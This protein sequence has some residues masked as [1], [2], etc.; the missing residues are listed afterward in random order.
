MLPI[1]YTLLEQQGNITT[2]AP[3][4]SVLTKSAVDLTN[5]NE[6][7]LFLETYGEMIKAQDLNAAATFFANWI[8]GLTMAQQ[9]MV[10]LCSSQVDLS[11]ENLTVHLLMRNGY[12]NICFQLNDATEIMPAAGQHESFRNVTLERFYGS[13]VTPL[14]ES[15]A[16]AGR[17]PLG[18]LWG[19]LPLTLWSFTQKMHSMVTDE[20]DKLRIDEDYLYIRNEMSLEVFKRK[21]NPFEMKFKEIDNPYNPSEPYWMRPACCQ[22][23][24]IGEYTYC[25]VCP[26]LTREQREIK[27]AEIEAT[28]AS[29]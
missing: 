24:R 1:D 29:R 17:A 3:P 8:R 11:V 28:V 4:E 26:K 13:T 27:K 2:I 5:P 10:S 7:R 18:Q 20:A 14:M 15:M 6:A 12:A 21:R 19:Q 9:Y 22:S 23:Y 16:E 25:Y